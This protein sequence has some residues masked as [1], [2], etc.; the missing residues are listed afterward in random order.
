MKAPSDLRFSPPAFLALALLIVA[1]L[2]ITDEYI[3]NLMI[4]SL[5]FGVQAMVFDFTAGFIGIVN[6]GFAAFLGLGAY[7]SALSAIRLGLSPWLGM[8]LGAGVAG[9]VGWLTAI[10][11][12]RLSGIFA[13]VMSWFVGLTLLSLATALVPLTRGSLGLSVPPLLD[14]AER[15]PFFFALLPLAALIYAVLRAITRSRVGLAFRAIGDNVE[16]ARASG[17]NPSRYRSL[18]FTISCFFAGLL[19]GFY[20]HFVGILTPEIMATSHTVEV[21]ALAYIGGRGS[22][23]GGL[24]A[25][26]LVIPVF[27][28]LKP[29]FEIRLVIYG[30]LLIAVM[31][32]VP[33]GLAGR[34]ARL[35]RGA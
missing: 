22:L 19:G 26:F 3:L 31:I 27:E 13:T 9:I 35:R 24:A 21:L 30:L 11:T 1:G 32:Y 18:N 34:V 2:L 33:D 20:A 17:I 7:V 4:V 8:W 12:L 10:L 29:L 23:W 16:A 28:F 25:A 14:A 15:R 5:F 6:F